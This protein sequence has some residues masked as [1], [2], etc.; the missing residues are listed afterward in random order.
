MGI[1][2]IR[3]TWGRLP[4]TNPGVILILKVRAQEAIQLFEFILIEVGGLIRVRWVSAQDNQLQCALIEEPVHEAVRRKLG[5]NISVPLAHRSRI[6]AVPVQAL[7]FV[8]CSVE[9]FRE[10]GKGDST[11]VDGL[12]NGANNPDVPVGV[13]SVAPSSQRWRQYSGLAVSVNGVSAD[14]ELRANLF[15]R[16]HVSLTWGDNI[17]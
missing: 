8:G 5:R 10:I 11:V 6:P 15:Y 3:G 9:S 4:K 12:A 13:V 2:S 14:S 7:F 17:K 16:V 1:A